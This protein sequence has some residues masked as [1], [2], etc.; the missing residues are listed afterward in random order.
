MEEKLGV[1][2]CSGYGIGEALDI[3]ALQKVATGEYKA[4]VC[5]TIASCAADDLAALRATAEEQ[6]LSHMVIAGP[7]SRF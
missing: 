1:F 6:Q 3:E 4:A 7:S 2:I 5:E